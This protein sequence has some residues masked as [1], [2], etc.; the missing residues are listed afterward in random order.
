MDIIE[1]EPMVSE[2]IKY[3]QNYFALSEIACTQ[4]VQV[5]RRRLNTRAAAGG[6]TLPSSMDRSIARARQKV[7]N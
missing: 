2:K 4:P 6:D 7:A 5:G 1:I 3:C